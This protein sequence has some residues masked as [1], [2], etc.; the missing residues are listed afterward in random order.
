M[1]A[2]KITRTM[3]RPSPAAVF[4]KR[5]LAAVALSAMVL[6]SWSADRLWPRHMRLSA[7]HRRL[8]PKIQGRQIV[9]PFSNEIACAEIASFD[10]QLEAF[11]RYE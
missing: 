10:D 11:L 7:Q 3:L 5:A 8:A 6:T 9:L 1:P 2:K 4:S